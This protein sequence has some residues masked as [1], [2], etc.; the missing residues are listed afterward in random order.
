MYFSTRLWS[1]KR[2]WAQTKAP[3]GRAP[4]GVWFVPRGLDH[5]N[6]EGGGTWHI[7]KPHW[8]DFKPWAHRIIDSS[9]KTQLG[10]HTTTTTRFT[11]AGFQSKE[12]H[13]WLKCKAPVYQ[14]QS[15]SKI[16]FLG[17]KILMFSSKYILNQAVV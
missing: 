14:S 3:L 16:R 8:A 12:K 9:T 5:L 10:Q 13:E 1:C 17:L 15:L 11:V 6:S 2:V 7:A 4:P